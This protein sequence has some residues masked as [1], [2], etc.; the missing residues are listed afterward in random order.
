[1]INSTIFA[2]S[3][4]CF[5]S[6]KNSTAAIGCLYVH[7]DK[8]SSGAMQKCF[9][10]ME[11]GSRLF[12]IQ[13]QGQLNST[14]FLVMTHEGKQSSCLG[15]F[16]APGLNCLSFVCLPAFVRFP[17]TQKDQSRSSNAT[18]VG[19]SEPAL[20]LHATSS[21]FLCPASTPRS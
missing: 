17:I 3:L 5:A 1:M 13:C 16:S 15:F 4:E 19:L 10:H 9:S 14:T 8:A 7:N 6:N 20:R 2:A 11:V 21:L 18:G 12:T